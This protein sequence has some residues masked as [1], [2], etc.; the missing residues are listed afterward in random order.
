M[1]KVAITGVIG[2]GKSTLANILREQG[3]T[4]IDADEI[5][6]RLT[7]KGLPIYHQI[8]EAFGNEVLLPNGEINRKKLAEMVFSNQ[9]KRLQLEKIIHPAVKAERDRIIAALE[10]TDKNAI[11]ILDIP[12]LFETGMEKDV[13]YIILAYADEKTLFERVQKRDSMSFEEFSKRLKNQMPLSSKIQKCH[14]VV[15]T[16]KD[17]KTLKKEVATII[18]TIKT[19]K[20]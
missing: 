6:R 10:K 2:S 1:L 13:D 16:R 12:L 8:I 15:D 5:S 19:R 20:A 9:D 17:I 11:V 18:E 4:V 7:K 3:M 14:F